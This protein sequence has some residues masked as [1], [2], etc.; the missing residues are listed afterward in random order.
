MKE[1]N[2]LTV[3]GWALIIGGFVARLAHFSVLNI[4]YSGYLITAFGI[5]VLQFNHQEKQENID[6]ENT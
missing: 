6:N 1:I 5:G 2:W 3:L 4:P